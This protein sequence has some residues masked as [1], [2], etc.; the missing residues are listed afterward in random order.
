[1]LAINR[2]IPS[3]NAVFLLL[4]YPLKSDDDRAEEKSLFPHKEAKFNVFVLQ[5]DL[6]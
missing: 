3:Q 2:F 6:S 4:T 5:S 1:M